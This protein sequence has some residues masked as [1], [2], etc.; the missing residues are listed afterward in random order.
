MKKL[1]FKTYLHTVQWVSHTGIAKRFLPFPLRKKIGHLLRKVVYLSTKLD[2]ATPYEIYGHKMWLYPG[3]Q[4]MQDIV[5]GT[6]E[7]ETVEIFR[8]IVKPGMTVVDVGAF[9]GYYSLLAARLVGRQGKVYAFEPNPEAFAILSRNI[10][11]NG[12]QRVIRAIPKAVSNHGGKVQLFLAERE[13]AQT[14]LYPGK[15]G[16]NRSV[17]VETVILDEFFS[18]EGWP[19]VHVVKIDVEGAEVEVLGGMKNLVRKNPQIKIFIEFNPGNQMKS[20]GNYDK[21][22][23]VLTKLGFSRFYGIYDRKKAVHIPNDIPQL[24]KM[25]NSSIHR[26]INLLCEGAE[27]HEQ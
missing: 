20:V 10:E 19:E 23:D 25:A 24:V 11:E 7:R 18:Q 1:L 14:S 17:D 9:I 15:R 27:R 2:P 4:Q 3:S 6:Y 13:A 21:L 8:K 5:F 16:A 22:F 26:Y 12:Y